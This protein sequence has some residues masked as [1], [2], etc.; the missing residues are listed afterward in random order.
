M[1]SVYSSALRKKSWGRVNGKRQSHC[2]CRIL[3]KTCCDYFQ[4]F[5]LFTLTKNTK[6][7]Q[8]HVTL[9]TTHWIKMQQQ[10]SDYELFPEIFSYILKVWCGQKESR[11]LYS[12]IRG[13]S[14]ILED[15]RSRMCVMRR[16]CP[17]I[18]LS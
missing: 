7:I 5:S 3:Q 9:G 15:I 2:F 17:R 1:K 10:H 18:M 16:R 11:V 12:R 8:M 6:K 14:P 13:W 4:N